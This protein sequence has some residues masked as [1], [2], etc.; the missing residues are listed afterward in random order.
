MLWRRSQKSVWF[1][2]WFF[3]A[4]VHFDLVET[5][6]D[7]AKQKCGNFNGEHGQIEAAMHQLY[8]QLPESVGSALVDLVKK[9]GGTKK[10]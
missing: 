4:L 5:V 1:Q 8:S 10:I 6:I 7:W 9:D 2:V 3:F